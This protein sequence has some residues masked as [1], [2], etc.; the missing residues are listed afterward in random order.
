MNKSTFKEKIIPF[1]EFLHNEAIGGVILLVVTIL[2][3]IF[4]NLPTAKIFS[5]IWRFEIHINLNGLSFGF[6][7]L[8]AIN[9][10]LMVLFFFVVGLEIK[11]ELLVGELSSLKKAL[12]PM[13]GAVGGMIIPAIIYLIFNSGGKG[14]DGWAIPVATDIAFVVGI[15][16]LLKNSIPSSLRIFLTALA[17]V[18][19]IG[20]VV[21]IAVFYTASISLPALMVAFLFIFFLILSNVLGVKKLSVY[22]F[23][24]VGLWFA[25][26][27]S[28][29]HTT[30][31]GVIL[32]FTIPSKSKLD[33]SSFLKST[34]RLVVEIGSSMLPST[35]K[36]KAEE[37]LAIIQALGKNC[38]DA[39]TPLQRFEINLH[40]WVTFFIIPVFAFAN[41][42]VSIGNN[43]GEFLFD[44]VC[45]G[46]V[47]GLFLGKQLGIFLFAYLAI[48]LKFSESPLDTS[49][50]QLYGASVLAGIGFTMSLFIAGLS[51]SQDA[52]LLDTARI[53]IL[54]ASIISGG[55]GYFLL[56]NRSQ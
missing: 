51:F 30:I 42:G 54:I 14:K 26:L 24:G 16:V 40:P 15:L 25:F 44:P 4:S 13:I 8:H 37:R 23:L 53:G 32:A 11:R 41:A 45:L 9:D 5:D 18:D 1:S 56:H 28:G 55:A 33:H 27:Q 35:K 20:A 10:G 22:I 39:L 43:I 21:I 38:R 34:K 12:L 7:L 3:I 17:I 47:F 31:A 50:K 19:D 29:I 52:A 36:E 49:T 46:I 48:R 6:S 2:A